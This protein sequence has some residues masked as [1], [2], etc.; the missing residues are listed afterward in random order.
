[1][2][3]LSEGV[4]LKGYLHWTLTDNYEWQHGFEPRFGLIEMNYET[5]ERKVRQ[6]AAIFK[7][8]TYL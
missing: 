2:Q 6:S 3:A 7:E 5:Q 8:I 1:M 4:D